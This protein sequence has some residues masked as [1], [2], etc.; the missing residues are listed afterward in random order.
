MAELY[1][2]WA[3]GRA[4]KAQLGGGNL[5]WELSKKSRE[6]HPVLSEPGRAGQ[7]LLGN[8]SSTSVSL[9]ARLPETRR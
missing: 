5:G 8:V 2:A 9:S 6:E 7:L 3:W 4:A 1:R